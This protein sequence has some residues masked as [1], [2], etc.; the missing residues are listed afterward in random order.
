MT[1][2]AEK[3][4]PIRV[5]LA[6]LFLLILFSTL[7][8]A[9][10][11][12]EAESDPE[13]PVSVG[14]SRRSFQSL[15]PGVELCS[16]CELR[17]TESLQGLVGEWT[18]AFRDDKL[19]WYVFNAYEEVVT[20]DNFERFRQAAEALIDEYGETH[21]EPNRISRGISSFTNP[22]TSPHEG[23]EVLSAEWQKP[24]EILSLRFNFIGDRGKY[25]FLLTL[26]GKRP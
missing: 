2:A 18:Y 25:S 5:G 24:G 17:R 20:Q 19:A 26:E 23:Y 3:T 21:G 10:C 22:H 1:Q 16:S 14:M 4:H 13:S 12:D 8:A 11:T 9:S 7:G 15:H 6:A